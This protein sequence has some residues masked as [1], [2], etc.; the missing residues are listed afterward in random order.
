MLQILCD[1][2]WPYSMENNLISTGTF[3]NLCGRSL[4]IPWWAYFIS[5]KRLSFFIW[6]IVLSHYTCTVVEKSWSPLYRT[7]EKG[8]NGRWVLLREADRK[9]NTALPVCSRS[10]GNSMACC[11][12]LENMEFPGQGMIGSDFWF[13]FHVIRREEFNSTNLPLLV[14]STLYVLCVTPLDSA[15]NIYL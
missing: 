13:K 3:S 1:T 11:D 2:V 10:F 12:I 9:Q 5:V 7:E 14:S 15:G 4:W 8:G 6:K